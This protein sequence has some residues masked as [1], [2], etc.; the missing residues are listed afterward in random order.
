MST[1]SQFAGGGIKSV[2]TGY[3]ATS[4]L[5]SGTGE[6]VK[7]FDVTVSTVTDITK[8]FV[9]FNGSAAAG[10]TGVAGAYFFSTSVIT[11]APTIK[12]ISPTTIRIMSNSG[13]IFSITG[14]W[15]LVEYN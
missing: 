3:I 9:T 14:R 11:Y 6:E 13:S 12:I 1:L 10:G 8:C 2:Q 7:Y 5:S 4:S 15:T